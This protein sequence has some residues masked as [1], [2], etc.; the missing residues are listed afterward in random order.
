[1]TT[2]N[3]LIAQSLRGFDV[4]GDLQLDQ[5]G[6]FMPT[7]GAVQ[8]FD[9]L[10]AAHG[11]SPA[12]IRSNVLA[13]AK[14]GVPACEVERVMR[15]Y[16]DYIE[17]RRYISMRLVNGGADARIALKIMRDAQREFFGKADAARMFGIDDL[18]TPVTVEKTEREAPARSQRMTSVEHRTSESMRS[19]QA[20]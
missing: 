20:R 13:A 15:L 2:A 11:Q 8:L 3:Q 12:E 17:Y 10:L 18:L 1:M 7:R 9:A 14:S 16:D 19:A 6:Y 5:H 4:D